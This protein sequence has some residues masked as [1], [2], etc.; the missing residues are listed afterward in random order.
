MYFTVEIDVAGASPYSPSRLHGTPKQPNEDP[1]SYDQRTWREHCHVN[2][3]GK[4]FIPGICFKQAL[5]SAAK[6]VSMS[7]PGQRGAKFGK[8]F[9]AA[10]QCS[11]DLVLPFTPDD[12]ALEAI[13]AHADGRR[14]SGKRVTRRFPLFAEWSGTLVLYVL[15]PIIK[16]EVLA[17]HFEAAGKFIGVG[18]FRPENGGFNG[19]F[20]VKA[21]RW[22]PRN[23]TSL[24]DAA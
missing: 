6:Y 8:K 21:I 4:V 16:E 14:G 2:K 5:D 15:D 11:E 18:R 1:D 22:T 23:P 20:I 3:A 24:A 17:A 12:A 10:I 9:A 19:R 13:L 7:V